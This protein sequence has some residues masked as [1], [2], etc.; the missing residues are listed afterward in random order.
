MLGI[1]W[2]DYASNEEDLKRTRLPSTESILLQC[3]CAGLVTSQG[4]KTYV[5]L[6]QSSSASSKREIVVVVLEGSVQR[7]AEETTCT[8]GN[9]SSVMAA[10]GLRLRQLTLISEKSRS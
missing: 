9:Q 8:G 6:K 1:K 2:Q 7:P 4:W 5:C 10:G 3:S